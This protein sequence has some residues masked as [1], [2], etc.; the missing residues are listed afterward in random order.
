MSYTD[1]ESGKN[2]ECNKFYSEKQI[3]CGYSQ[4]PAPPN[5]LRT[6]NCPTCPTFPRVPLVPLLNM[7]HLTT[8][9][10]PPSPAISVL[11]RFS[12]TD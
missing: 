7:S 2:I 1:P 6:T 12:G 5:A 11:H 10:Y 8:A 4:T 9:L 3:T